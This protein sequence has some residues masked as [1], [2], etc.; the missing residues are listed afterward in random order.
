MN[1]YHEL[2]E[3]KIE[4]R[5]AKDHFETVRAIVEMSVTTT[6]KNAEDRKR[7]LTVAVA[8]DDAYQA[9]LGNLRGCE[10]DL[11]RAQANID[12]AEAERRDREWA[13]RARLAEA[14]GGQREDAAFEVVTDRRA[15]YDAMRSFSGAMNHLDDLYPEK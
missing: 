9:A 10:A 15:S 3:A 2:A 1:P 7:E 4:L 12:A 6:G 8:K 14:L 5:Q 11:D 13:I